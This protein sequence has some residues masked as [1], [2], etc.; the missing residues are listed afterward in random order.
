M[1]LSFPNP[2][3]VSHMNLIIKPAEGSYWHKGAYEFT[4][5]V[6]ESEYPYQPP[7]IHCNTPVFHPNIDK[8]GNVCLNILRADWTPILTLIQII[9]GLIFLFIEPNPT[10]PLNLEAAEV[11]RNDKAKFKQI[12]LNTL[13]G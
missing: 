12:V 7:K 13:R 11:M 2:K 10:D 1:T 5:D 4:I 9:N 8:L 6:D 3:V